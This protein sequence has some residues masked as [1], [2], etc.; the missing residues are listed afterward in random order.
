MTSRRCSANR[1][2]S[3]T[4][5]SARCS[6]TFWT[7]DCRT[8]CTRSDDEVATDP[9]TSF[10]PRFEHSKR[11][12]TRPPT[13]HLHGHREPWRERPLNARGAGV[14]RAKAGSFTPRFLSHHN[15]N[16]CQGRQK[17]PPHWW[18]DTRCNSLRRRSICA[19]PMRRYQSRVNCFGDG[20]RR[21]WRGLRR[22]GGCVPLLDPLWRRTDE[23]HQG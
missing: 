15:R 18:R 5:I 19:R 4:A 21:R 11:P 17:T 6:T 10:A 9:A 13:S 8:V 14:H 20:E 23:A 16:R 2:T 1:S 7:S 12:S 22:C 3:C